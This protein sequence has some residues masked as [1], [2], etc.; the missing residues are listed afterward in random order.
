M[1]SFRI[2]T[3]RGIPIRIHFTLIAMFALLVGTFGWMG[4][5]AGILLFGSVLLHELGHSIVAQYHRIP[6]TSITLHLMGGMAL[7]AR[8]PSSA[9]QEIEIAAAGPLVSL[10]LGLLFVAGVYIFGGDLSVEHP[11][12]IAYGAL[13]N[14]GM[15]VFNLIPALPM[16]GGRIFRAAL[17]SKLGV[18]RA[19]R[20][21][22]TVTRVFAALFMVVGLYTRAWSLLIIGALLL[23]MVSHEERVAEAQESMKNET[24]ELFID[25]YGRRYIVITRLSDSLD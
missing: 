23:F 6:I 8:P 2:A 17:S 5:P 21:A 22:A 1:G 14:L 4:V 24:R 10:V 20:I 7:M 9:K 3:I 11:S 16:D 15:F 13:V 25:P 12:L 18:L 19:T